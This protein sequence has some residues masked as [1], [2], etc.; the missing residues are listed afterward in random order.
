MGNDTGKRAFMHNRK[1]TI[2]RTGVDRDTKN[3][4][5]NSIWMFFFEPQRYCFVLDDG[6][7]M[8][9]VYHLPL[10]YVVLWE[11]SIDK[12]ALCHDIS[13]SHS[14]G[15]VS[16]PDNGDGASGFAKRF[17]CFASSPPGFSCIHV[18]LDYTMNC[19][20]TTLDELSSYLVTTF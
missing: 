9:A 14:L 18:I 17:D 10:H 11:Y 8:P 13:A 15:N 1:N 7:L 20:M 6:H 2:D 19:W 12:S 4:D 5:C 16:I 3:V